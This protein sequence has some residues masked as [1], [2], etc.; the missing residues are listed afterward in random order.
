MNELSGL[1]IVSPLN[2]Q[3]YAQELEAYFHLRKEV[4]IDQR[5]WDLIA[6]DGRE[7]DQFDHEHAHYLLFKSNEAGEVLGG[8][9]LTPSVAPN[10][11][12]DIF[13]HLIDPCHGFARSLQVWEASRFVTTSCEMGIKKGLIREITLLLFIGMIEYGLSHNVH[14]FLTMTEIRLERIARMVGWHLRRLGNVEQVGNTYAVVGLAE[15]SESMRQ[16]MRASAEISRPVFLN[17]LPHL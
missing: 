3:H 9:R 4:L 8:V 2:R 5:G 14:S 1:C 15:V 11:T 6:C 10:L 17:E 16:K 12:M 13:S 7:M